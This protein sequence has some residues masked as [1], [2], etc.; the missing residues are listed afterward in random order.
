MAKI[1]CEQNREVKVMNLEV[2]SDAMD[3]SEN[4]SSHQVLV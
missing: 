2:I 3:R 1:T 4:I